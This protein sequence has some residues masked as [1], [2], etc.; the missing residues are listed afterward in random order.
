MTGMHKVLS[1]PDVVDVA[2]LAREIW[3]AHYVPIIG[4]AQVD[5]MLEKFQS[6]AVIMRQ[7]EE[8]YEYYLAGSAGYLA[9]V[10]DGAA[11]AL[12][13]SKIY[14][15]SDFRGQGIGC[16]MLD[17]AES[18]GRARGLSC[19]WLTVNRHNRESIAWYERM[20]F[21]KAG[22]LVQDIGGG[23]VMDDFK[24]VKTLS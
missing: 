3:N 9:V 6:A 20:G 17:F 2:A 15:R 12:M 21:V 8:G 1:L 16:R 4:Q 13:I 23:F 7:L 24:M 14:V 19:L 18:L 22:T 5:Y 11:S 10:P